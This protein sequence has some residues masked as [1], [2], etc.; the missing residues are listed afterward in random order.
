MINAPSALETS[1]PPAA[2]AASD[3]YNL[4]NSTETELTIRRTTIEGMFQSELN[5]LDKMI[6]HLE[7]K[8]EENLRQLPQY[9]LLYEAYQRFRDAAIKR[10]CPGS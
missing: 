6:E 7:A 3:G 10:I 9:E 4:Q 2:N 5:S 8:S 1:V